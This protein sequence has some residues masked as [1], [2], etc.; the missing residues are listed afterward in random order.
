MKTPWHTLYDRF[1]PAE[2]V[3]YEH[4]Q[5]RANRPYG[6]ADDLK[7]ELNRPFGHK[8]FL[9]LGTVGSGKT[10]E[11]QLLAESRTERAFVVLVDL[12]AFFQN[13][14]R[15]T[16]AMQH[17]QP[18]EVIF[19]IG[20]HVFR[21][22]EAKGHTWPDDRVKALKQAYLRLATDEGAAPEVDIAKLAASLVVVAG[23][24]LGGASAVAAGSAVHG[25]S[26]IAA[27]GSWKARLGGRKPITDQDEPVKRLVDAVTALMGDLNQLGR[28]VTCFV[29][30]LDRINHLPTVKALFVESSLLSVLPCELVL[31]A[32]ILVRQESLVSAIARFSVKVLAN[33][34]VLDRQRPLEVTEVGA[35]F[36]Q[37]AWRKRTEDL[38][39]EQVIEDAHLRR[40]AWASG[41][42]VRQFIAMINDVATECFDAGVDAS[43][44]AIIERVVDKHRRDLEVG[45]TREDLDLLRT[46]MADGELRAGERVTDLITTFRLLPYPNESE[47]YYPHPLLLLR[48][49]P[50]ESLAG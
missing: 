4:P 11:L 1:N 30:G 12:W 40:L 37:T 45:I 24:L 38:G 5:W 9:L 27:S 49:L 44:P 39:L 31:V 32:S 22:A 7:P 17:I 14:L 3:P 28:P 21:A 35:R 36:C 15:D 50:P 26:Q 8:R 33:V 41:G 34:P 6:P 19:L 46:I 13:N 23:G 16:Q 25:L 2:P 18:W 29:D 43:T 47:W 20:M 10:T 42:R 48:K